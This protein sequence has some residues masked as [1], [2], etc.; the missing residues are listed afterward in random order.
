MESGQIIRSE[1]DLRRWNKVLRATQWITATSI[2]LI[3]IIVNFMLV[4]NGA[5]GYTEANFTSMLFRYLFLT[6]LINYGNILLSYLVCRV[7]RLS[8]EKAKYVIMTS[9]I[10]LCAN[11]TFSHYQFAC[12]FPVYA[13]PITVS[14]LYENKKFTG[15][16]LAA[17]L[18]AVM[19]GIVSRIQDP[20]YSAD[21]IPE[22][23]I[24]CTFIIV[25]GFIAFFIINNQ[26]Y[27]R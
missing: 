25:F 26:L 13:I 27:R 2:L 8:E 7:F 10:L 5:Q 4:G 19:P 12:V 16:S 21:A 23:C 18:L 9:V 20:L 1:N 17:S 14:V 15:Y 3:E 6:S 22:A 24:S 11:I